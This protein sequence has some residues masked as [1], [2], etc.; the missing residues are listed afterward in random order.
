ML[1]NGHNKSV[2]CRVT[3]SENFSLNICVIFE[4]VGLNNERFT[5]SGNVCCLRLL[6][7]NFSARK[8]GIFLRDGDVAL[9]GGS[10]PL[11]RWPLSRLY[12]LLVDL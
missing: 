7:E 6:G 9:L 5:H 1:I 2:Y 4:V 10:A 11:S 3:H 12:Y 8:C